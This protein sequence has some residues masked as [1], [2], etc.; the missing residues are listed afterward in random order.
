MI[1]AGRRLLPGEK[2]APPKT[3]TRTVRDLL[4]E[5][6]LPGSSHRLKVPAFSPLVGQTL[7]DSEIG[8]NFDVRVIMIERPSTLGMGITTAPAADSVIHNGDILVV[9]GTPDAIAALQDSCKLWSQ[10]VT[11]HDR[12]RW[13]QETGIAKVLIHPESSLI[14]NSLRKSGLRSS[15]GI[16]VLGLRRKNKPK[17]AFLDTNLKSG[18]AMLVVGQLVYGIGAAGPH[19]MLAA[20]FIL[21][22][23]LSMVLSGTPAAILLAPVAIRA[24]SA[25]GVAPHAFGITVAIAASAGFVMPVSSAAVMLVMGPG[26]YRMRDF[27]KVGFPLLVLTGVVTII[28]API[29]F[30][31]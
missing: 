30:P 23:A 17:A 10:S 20:L 19:L 26:K 28:L 27:F 12:A 4:D 7:A 3:P 29:L 13:M 24:A 25:L 11:H 2:M 1:T 18:D 31:F 21:T 8:K 9:R 14:G 22:A 6:E 15:Y 16:Q 5:F